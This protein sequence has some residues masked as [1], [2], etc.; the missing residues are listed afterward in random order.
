MLFEDILI[1]LI[2][3]AAVFLIG[4]PLY[5][6]ARHL[7]P[8]KRNPLAEAKERLEVARLEAEAIKLNKETEHVYDH[9]YE[10]A[11]EDDTHNKQERDH[12]E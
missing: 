1:F 12:H 6:I 3:G 8:K 10:E 7:I 4:I 9:M 2:C 11:L 5:K